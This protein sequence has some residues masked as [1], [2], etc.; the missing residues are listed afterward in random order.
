MTA[1]ENFKRI[2]AEFRAT[3]LLGVG[4][5]SLLPIIGKFSGFEPVWP[6][7]VA[8]ITS[9]AALISIIIAFQFHWKKS[10]SVMQSM[11]VKALIVSTLFFLVYFVV[12]SLFTYKIPTTGESI[13]L[14]C[15]WTVEAKQ[16]ADKY[17]ADPEAGCPGQYFKMLEAAQYDSEILWRIESLT[18]IRILGFCSW[19]IA[20]T[21]FSFFIALFVI[22]HSYAKTHSIK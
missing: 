6:S 7:G 21:S 18:L 10:R 17:L 3:L 19:I 20:F 9:L 15:G 11:M 4:S 2:F 13:Y 14:G 12:F 8:V 16:L 22:Y 1:L 5:S